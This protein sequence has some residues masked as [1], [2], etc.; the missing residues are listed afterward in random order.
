MAR[1][2]ARVRPWITISFHRLHTQSKSHWLKALKLYLVMSPTC[3]K[4]DSECHFAVSHLYAH[5]Y[6]HTWSRHTPSFYG[7]GNWHP[8]KQSDV[9]ESHCLLEAEW[10]LL[11]LKREEANS[12]RSI[13]PR[14]RFNKTNF[15]DYV[16]RLCFFFFFWRVEN[17][18]TAGVPHD[19]ITLLWGEI[20]EGWWLGVVTEREQLFQRKKML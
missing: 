20:T 1:D 3:I 18:S 12:G 10:I 6:D 11:F 14:F 19:S 17:A 5:S 8:G 7:W 13:N 4:E 15:Y 9:P 16:S 2:G